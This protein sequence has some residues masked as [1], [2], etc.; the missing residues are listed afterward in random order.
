M[1]LYSQF[2]GLLFQTK[3]MSY[4]NRKKELKVNLLYA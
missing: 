2:Q 3:M 4:I 1:E